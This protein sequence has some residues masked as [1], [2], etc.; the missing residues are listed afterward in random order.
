[1]SLAIWKLYTKKNQQEDFDFISFTFEED[2]VILKTKQKYHLNFPIC[3]ISKDS[4]RLLT[5]NIEGYPSNYIVNKKNQ[6]EYVTIGGPTAK[7]QIELLFKY[8]YEAPT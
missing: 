5:F 7:S 2:S 8:E 1:V 6:V 4:C 3:H